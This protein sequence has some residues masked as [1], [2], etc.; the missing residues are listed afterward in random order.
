MSS[1]NLE[2]KVEY[3]W[4]SN[5]LLEEK[6]IT[7]FCLYCGGGSVFVLQMKNTKKM[8]QELFEKID[9]EDDGEV[10]LRLIK[11]HNQS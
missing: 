11:I 9:Q 1:S 6:W 7:N 8:F 5:D 3:Q 4:I 2:F 10:Y